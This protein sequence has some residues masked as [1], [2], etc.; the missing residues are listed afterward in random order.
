MEEDTTPA[1]VDDGGGAGTYECPTCSRTLGSAQQLLEHWPDCTSAL[2]G[3]SGSSGSS[4]SGIMLGDGGGGGRAV[5]AWGDDRDEDSA[6]TFTSSRSFDVSP[7]MSPSVEVPNALAIA[8][9][10]NP[11]EVRKSIHVVA[12]AGKG[13][14][15]DGAIGWGAP[16]NPSAH[17]HSQTLPMPPLCPTQSRVRICHFL[18]PTKKKNR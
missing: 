3:G 14:D 8:A 11:I 6:S 15:S 9:L 1:P 13:I 10:E 4:G 17:L 7:P 2:I 18:R 12:S 16:P 5:G